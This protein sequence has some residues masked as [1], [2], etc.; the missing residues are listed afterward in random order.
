MATILYLADL[1]AARAV[2]IS[3]LAAV[4]Q[5][6]RSTIVRTDVRTGLVIDFYPDV[7]KI[8]VLKMHLLAE[9]GV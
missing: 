3:R 1:T 5:S 7:L 4:S 2:S 6:A 9:L 8:L